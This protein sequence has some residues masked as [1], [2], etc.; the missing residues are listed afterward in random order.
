MKYAVEWL[1]GRTICFALESLVTNFAD[2][3][4]YALLPIHAHGYRLVMMAEKTGK[5]RFYTCGE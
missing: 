4:G 1:C 2:E 3:L 5:G